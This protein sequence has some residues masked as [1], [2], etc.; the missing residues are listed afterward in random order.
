MLRDPLARLKSDFIYQTSCRHPLYQTALERYP[1]FRHFVEDPDDQNVM[2]G[3]LCRSE[4]ESIQTTIDFILDHYYWIG[5]QEDY[6]FSIKVLFMLLGM[7]IEPQRHVNAAAVG[8]HYR[9]ELDSTDIRAAYDRNSKEYQLYTF[10]LAKHQARIKEFY[11]T[12]DHDRFFKKI[13]DT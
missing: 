3:Y 6:T 4:S 8:E 2:F 7:R 5:I 12:I 10:F 9:L 13:I 1:S 11:E